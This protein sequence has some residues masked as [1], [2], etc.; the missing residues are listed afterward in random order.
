M[1]CADKV[2]SPTGCSKVQKNIIK[3]CSVQHS[4][5]RQLMTLAECMRKLDLHG[6]CLC[7][8]ACVHMR[9]WKT[10]H[11]DITVST[12]NRVSKTLVFHSVAYLIHNS[13]L[14]LCLSVP[15]M[16]LQS[17]SSELNQFNYVLQCC[18]SHQQKVVKS[19]RF[20][21]YGWRFEG[22]MRFI[23]SWILF[24]LFW[25]PLHTVTVTLCSPK[26]TQRFGT[27][28]PTVSI[29]VSTMI[30]LMGMMASNINC[31]FPWYSSKRSIVSWEKGNEMRKARRQRKWRRRGTEGKR[32]T[33]K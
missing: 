18:C 24:S 8:C 12:G 25:P 7:V 4:W 23:T 2:C 21:M 11:H 32:D 1:T 13:R 9:L 27:K 3:W 10:D 29:T 17:G 16:I 22:K 15:H 31:N 6:Q 33:G 19:Y 5:H 28:E 20:H 26:K 14:S 30:S